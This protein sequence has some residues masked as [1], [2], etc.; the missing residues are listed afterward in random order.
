MV[1]RID[2]ANHMFE[3][4]GQRQ[5]SEEIGASLAAPVLAFMR[6]HTSQG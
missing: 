6:K 4:R 3:V 5:P 1:Q 2:G